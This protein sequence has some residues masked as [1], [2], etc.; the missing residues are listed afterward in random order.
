MENNVIR[1]VNF[2]RAKTETIKKT[3]KLKDMFSSDASLLI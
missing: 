2:M 1:R 3:I